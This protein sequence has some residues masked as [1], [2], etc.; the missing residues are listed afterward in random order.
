MK[1]KTHK[2]TAHM[3]GSALQLV[4][5]AADYCQ[6]TDSEYATAVLVVA[7]RLRLVRARLGWRRF[8]SLQWW[9]MVVRV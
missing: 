6:L 5:D 8:L 2:V 1:R 4:Q 3:S 7:S 9:R